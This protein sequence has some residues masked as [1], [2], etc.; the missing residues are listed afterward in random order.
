MI[1]SVNVHHLQ[2][3]EKSSNPFE[4]KEPFDR[5]IISQSIAENV[6]LV[7]ADK[8]FPLYKDKNFNLITY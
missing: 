3:L 8:R 4:Q 7:S 2:V 5:L 1:Y 6:M